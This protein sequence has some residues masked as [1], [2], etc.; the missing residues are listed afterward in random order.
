[1]LDKVYQIY[2]LLGELEMK[3]NP[4]NMSAMSQIYDLLRD[5]RDGL[6]KIEETKA[7][8]EVTE[9]VQS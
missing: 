8:E 2:N 3:T 7:P 5:V 6:R 4:G 1:M 9:D